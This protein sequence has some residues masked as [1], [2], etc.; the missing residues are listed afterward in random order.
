MKINGLKN[1]HQRSEK[2]SKCA[3]AV[4]FCI[5]LKTTHRPLTQPYASSRWNLLWYTAV[6][7]LIDRLTY[8]GHC[9]A[10]ISR[11]TAA[12]SPPPSPRYM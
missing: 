10:I 6:N 7:C 11:F 9:L 2:G 3:R 8:A 1:I 12:T 4:N 5:T